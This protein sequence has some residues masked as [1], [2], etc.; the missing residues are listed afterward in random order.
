VGGWGGGRDG[1]SKPAHQSAEW[2]Q[3]RRPTKLGRCRRH[4][5]RTRP[6]Q[7]RR[8]RILCTVIVVVHCD[9]GAKPNRRRGELKL[10]PRKARK[11]VSRNAQRCCNRCTLVLARVLGAVGR[12]GAVGRAVFG[13]LGPSQLAAVRGAK[14]SLCLGPAVS[15]RFAT[16]ADADT[17]DHAMPSRRNASRRSSHATS[18]PAKRKA[19]PSAARGVPLPPRRPTPPPPPDPDSQS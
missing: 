9:G 15:L 18:R 5:D 11:E 7:S 2:A 3:R 4:V 6:R 10:R 12:Y 14:P 19:A 17:R 16:P 13:E 8:P 1:R